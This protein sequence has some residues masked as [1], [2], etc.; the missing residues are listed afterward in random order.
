MTLYYTPRLARG[1]SPGG[2]ALAESGASVVNMESH[3]ILAVETRAGVPAVVL[4]VV[5]DSLNRPR[6]PNT[7]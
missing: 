1:S 5:S 2:L 3:A 4:R 7:S 6:H